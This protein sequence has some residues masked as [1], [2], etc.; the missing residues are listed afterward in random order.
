MNRNET[1][2]S[3][4]AVIS[5]L[6]SVACC[7]PWGFLAALGATGVSV[8]SVSLRPWL[9]VLSA[10]LLG[11]GF[12]QLYRSG[13]TCARRSVASIVLFWTATVVVIALILFPQVIAG[14][15]ADL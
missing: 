12:V 8:L 7:L 6:A 10:I 15:L 4:A 1:V 13:R 3:V 11:A 2:A 9:L 5:A 14:F